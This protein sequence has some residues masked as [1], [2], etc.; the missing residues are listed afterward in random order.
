MKIRKICC[1]IVIML[2]SITVVIAKGEFE[3]N[4][5]TLTVYASKSFAGSWGAGPN[6]AKDFFDKTGIKV[7]Y[8][9]VGSGSSFLPKLQLERDSSSAD[10]VIGITDQDLKSASSYFSKANIDL[11]MINKDILLDK[12]ERLIPYDYG[13][14]AFN[15]DSTKT[16][17]FS[18]FNDLLSESYKGK[19]IISDPRTSS[20]G[21]A[22]LIWTILEMGEENAWKFWSSFKNNLLAI[23]DDWSSAYTLFSNKEAPI[24]FGF[25]TSVIWEALEGEPTNLPADF[26]SGLLKTVEFMGINKYSNNKENARAFMSYILSEGQGHITNANK[27]FSVRDDFKYDKSFDHAIKSKVD[28]LLDLDFIF[29]NKERWLSKWTQIMIE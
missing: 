3:K 27:M 11:S 1:L 18:S 15:Y 4:S 5:K 26:T 8:I 19:I 12:D 29:E 28:I 2:L 17:S 20:T 6:L 24:M 9:I 16:P 22:L 7:N 10:L 21:L 25:S 23:T 13:Y 14:Y